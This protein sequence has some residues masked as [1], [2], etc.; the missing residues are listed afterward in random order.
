[1]S[2]ASSELKEYEKIAIEKLM[3]AIP[4]YTVCSASKVFPESDVAPDHVSTS[5]TNGVLV[6]EVALGGGNKKLKA[7]PERKLA[8]DA[9]KLSILQSIVDKSYRIEKRVLIVRTEGVK[10]QFAKGW[11]EKALVASS[12][13]IFCP[14][15][16]DSELRAIEEILSRCGQ[17]N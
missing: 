17:K 3:Q 8:K 4:G 9:F 1:M 16:S 15:F 10:R 6:A 2:K 7:G 11:I 12:I 5:P 14:D 13:E